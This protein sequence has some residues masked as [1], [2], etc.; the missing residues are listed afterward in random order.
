MR[1][2]YAELGHAGQLAAWLVVSFS[3]YALASQLAWQLRWALQRARHD[4]DSHPE[5]EWRLLARA[6]GWPLMP[7]LEQAARFGYYLGIPFLAA[8]SGAIGADLLGIR[9]SEWVAGREDWARG[10]GLATVAVL[11][12]WS[13]WL[14]GRLL[15]RRQKLVPLPTRLPGS[16]WQRLLDALY[17]QIH[18][19]FYRSGPILWLDDVYWGIF[20]GLALVLL[21][22]A[23]NPA[24]RWAL[25]D[26][27]T[28]APSLLR[29]SIA[30]TSALLFL[31]TRNLWLTLAAHLALVGL[32]SAHYQDEPEPALEHKRQD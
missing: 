21:E 12:T 10:A 22:A 30:W 8:T 9:G 28:A 6:Q 7:W 5:D 20:A 11:A 25:Q 15:A 31:A 1:E 23:L 17:D 26:P 14:A 24:H 32:L 13:V 2:L 4:P 19:A 3:L 18:W 29:L 27:E 16:A